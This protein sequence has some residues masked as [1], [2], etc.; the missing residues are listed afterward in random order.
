M[1]WCCK[2]KERFI[3][4]IVNRIALERATIEGNSPVY[5]ND[6]F[7]LIMFLSTTMKVKL[8]GNLSKPLEKAKYFI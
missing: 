5:E 3:K 1:S 2:S 8:R 4:D 6:I 7:L